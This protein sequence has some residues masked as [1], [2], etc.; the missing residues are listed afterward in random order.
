MNNVN[1]LFISGNTE[2]SSGFIGHMA[3][4]NEIRAIL[5]RVV[6][7]KIDKCNSTQTV[8]YISTEDEK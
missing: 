8:S 5:H 2:Y 3:F 6:C 1:I 7:T 4:D